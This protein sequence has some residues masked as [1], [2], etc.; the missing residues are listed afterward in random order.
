MTA[1]NKDPLRAAILH[2]LRPLVRILLQHSV[3]YES[4]A[5]LAKWMYADVASKEF[6]LPGRKQTVSRV[7]VLTGLNRKE[8]VRVQQLPPPT[9]EEGA[10][11]YH[12]A[13]KVVTGWVLDYPMEG[14]ASGAAP[15]PMEGDHSFSSLVKRYSGDMPAR[16]VYDELLRVNAIRRNAEGEI[17]LLR[18]HYLQ[19]Q[20][21][22]RKLV[23][24]GHDTS[25]LISTIAHNLNAE[26]ADTF[27]QRKVLTDNIPVEHLP[28]LRDVARQ[29]GEPLLDKVAMEFSQHDRDSN[30]AIEGTQR[31]RAVLGIYYYEEPFAGEEPAKVEST[32]AHKRAVTTKDSPDSSATKKRDGA[33]KEKK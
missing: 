26:P 14:T 6:T 23:Y 15:L 4:F 27:L 22:T 16:A 2:L 24:L 1:N 3:P 30:P 19:P 11:S 32:R 25:D 18:R 5:D 17:E 29:L 8:V 7:S 31:M 33:Q 21:E 13:G 9:D 12:R 28:H 10:H 20:G